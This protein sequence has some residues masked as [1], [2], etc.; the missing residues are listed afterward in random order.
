MLTRRTILIDMMAGALAAPLQA[1]PIGTETYY[2]DAV[3]GNDAADGHTPATAWRTTDKVS[4]MTFNPGATVLFKRGQTFPLNATLRLKA[5][6]GGQR[7]RLDRPVSLGAYGPQESPMPKLSAWKLLDP[8]GW[9]RLAGNV[10]RIDVNQG[11]LSTGNQAKGRNGAN[12]G[13][14]LVEDAIKTDK[15]A[16][17]AD[18]TDDWDFYSDSDQFLYV[19]SAN[20]PGQTAAP[21]KA[22]P[23]MDM[24]SL[25]NGLVV[26]DLWFEGTGGHGANI[27]SNC[28]I[29]WCVFHTIGGSFLRGISRYGNG[30]QQ[31]GGGHN[32]VA[33]NNLFWECYD[34]ALTCQGFSMATPGAGWD[35]IDFSD[36]W[37]ARCAQGVEFWAMY[38]Q[39]PGRGWGPAGAGLRSVQARR[40]RLYDIGR[41]ASR[42]GRLDYRYWAC[43]IESAV[44]ETPFHPIPISVQF[45]RNCSDRVLIGPHRAERASG[46]GDFLLE[47]SHLSLPANSLIASG[48]TRR[49]EE[50]QQFVAETG[51]G[52]GSTMGIEPAAQSGFAPEVLT[53]FSTL[54]RDWHASRS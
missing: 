43:F 36:N 23:N 7:N 41:G 20:H 32:V 28:D 54:Y 10:W 3:A 26:R 37:I 30:I 12:I 48:S 42:L 44:V 52:I 22:S 21:I 8:Q 29:Q 1:L 40:L 33:R 14:L 31:F 38:G 47:A 51:I 25:D 5:S 46:V 50:W 35:N 53:P 17:L 34:V 4:A 16:R 6:N 24:L 13:R 9:T 2:V 15:K 49:V 39:G 45:M 19:K 18:L 11:L 27:G